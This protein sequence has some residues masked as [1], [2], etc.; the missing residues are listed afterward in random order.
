MLMYI[1]T[2]YAAPV[3]HH[4]LTKSQTDQIEATGYSEKSSQHHLY[5]H[6]WHAL[7]RYFVP[8]WTH[9]PHRMQKKTGLQVSLTL[10]K[11]RDHAYIT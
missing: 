11:N 3:W 10:W 1:V 5:Q 6:S 9:E 4:L 8:C 2:K 7:Y